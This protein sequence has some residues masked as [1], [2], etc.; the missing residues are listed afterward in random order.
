MRAF[1]YRNLR[2]KCWSI[3]A[4]EGPDKGHVIDHRQEVV[5]LDVQAR[6]QQ[7]GR[8]RVLRERVKNVHAGLAGTLVTGWTIGE[9]PVVAVSKVSYNP[10][11]APT[12]VDHLGQP[13]RA[14]DRAYL[15]ADGK[16]TA[17]NAR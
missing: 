12:F 15:G 14:M 7:G 10:Y 9:M 11:K 16:V 1:C 3:K 2:Q 17:L 13:V 4:L 8:Q 6:V 5:L